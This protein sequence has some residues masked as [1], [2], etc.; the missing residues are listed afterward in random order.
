MQPGLEE[1][2]RTRGQRQ[3]RVDGRAG[4]GKVL[5]DRLTRDEEAHDLARPF[6]D[7]VDARVP[8]GP[9]DGEGIFAALPQGVGGFVAAASPDLHRV[10]HQVPGLLAV[11]QLG[12]GR[13]EAHVQ[14]A[15]ARH[16]RGQFHGR[17]H[18]VGLGGHASQHLGDGVVLSDRRTPLDAF[19]RPLSA[20]TQQP[21][22]AAVQKAGSA[23]RP[24][25]RVMSASFSPSPSPHS[26]FSRGTFTS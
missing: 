5:V 8:Q 2:G 3:P 26:R 14:S 10:A 22:P 18:R 4:H 24:V 6:E 20:G 13:L 25:F 15:E 7:Q 21:L 19:A 16:G 1:G 9:F 12:H 11:P 23:S 17:F